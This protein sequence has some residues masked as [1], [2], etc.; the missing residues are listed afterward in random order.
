VHG[1]LGLV[2]P[3]DVVMLF[4]HSGE[5]EEITKLLEPLS[6]LC[7]AL[8]GVTG[9]R[10]SS[11]AKRADIALVYG[12][13]EE[14]CPL[15][16]APSASSTTML[17]LGDAVAF[18]SRVW[19]RS[20]PNTSHSDRRVFYAQYSRTVLGMAEDSP[21]ALAIPTC[22]DASASTRA[23]GRAICFLPQLVSAPSMTSREAEE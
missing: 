18:S 11:L 3:H 12:P 1:D 15:G 16:L 9:N 17:A 19:H 5:S 7:S 20:Q 10:E 4:S 13:L 2:H 14:V 21:L 8:I 22:P 23:M 6:E